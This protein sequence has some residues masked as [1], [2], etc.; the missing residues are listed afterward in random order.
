MDQHP[1][2]PPTPT[3]EKLR[4][5]TMIEIIA[6]GKFGAVWKSYEMKDM[7]AVKIMPFEVITY[8]LITYEKYFA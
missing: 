8:N 4:S 3:P 1:Q 6:R 2:S 5:I 7:V